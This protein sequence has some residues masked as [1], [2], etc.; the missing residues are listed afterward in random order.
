MQKYFVSSE[1]FSKKMITGDDVFHIKNVMRLS[2]GD[3]IIIGANKQSFIAIIESINSDYVSYK[4]KETIDGN[5]ELPFF[6]S[7]MQGFPKEDK[8]EE[9]IKHGT[10]LGASEFIPVLMKRSIVKLDK[11]RASKRTIRYNKIA[12]EAAEQSLR[13]IIPLCLEPKKLTEIDFS[14]YDYLVYCYECL[15]KENNKDFKKVIKSLKPNSKICI[16]IGPEG[17]IDKSEAEFLD[18]KGFVS[19]SLGKRI[20]RTETAV[21][22]CLS[23]ISYEWEL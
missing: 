12:K 10:E 19:V 3:E 1:S 17:G 22:Y 2:T 15:A 18:S 11:E 21:F 5:N 4:I 9:V 23:A 7:I 8:L 16:L 6:V 14:K 20:L 13:E